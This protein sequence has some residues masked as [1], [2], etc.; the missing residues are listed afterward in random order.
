M[1]EARGAEARSMAKGKAALGQMAAACRQ[2]NKVTDEDISVLR[3]VLNRIAPD[4]VIKTVVC[5]CWIK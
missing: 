5:Q 3:G 4:K 2:H 1:A